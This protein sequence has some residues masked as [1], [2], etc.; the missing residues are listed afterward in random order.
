M[1]HYTVITKKKVVFATN[2]AGKI[3]NIGEEMVRKISLPYAEQT[4]IILNSYF[5][6]YIKIIS[7]W[8]ID[9]REKIIKLL[10]ENTRKS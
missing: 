1:K 4:K 7:K 9:L 3:S 8:T 5:T 2:I 6:P 10:E